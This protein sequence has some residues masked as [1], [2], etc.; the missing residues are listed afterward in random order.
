MVSID[1]GFLGL[2]LY[3]SAKPPNDPATGLPTV[4]A[5][6]RVEQ[7]ID[8]LVAK[9]ERVIISAPAL[10]EF[11]VLAAD[12]GPQYLTEIELQ[13]NFYIQPFDELVAVELAAIELLARKRGQKRYPLPE[14]VPWQ[15]VKFDRQIVAVAKFHKAHTLY[16]D[17]G[18]IRAIAEDV[19]IK[20]V[21]CWE[22]E[23]PKGNP[24]LFDDI[25]SPSGV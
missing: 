6:E 12:D 22:L 2:F 10:A 25:D 14:S 24:S 7:L 20:G 5:K 13:S 17:D 16:S 3:P 11:L 18:D 8:D 9:R 23:V 4:Q 19:G 1:A 21:A 15:K